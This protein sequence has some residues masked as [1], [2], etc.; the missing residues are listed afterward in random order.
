MRRLGLLSR[1]IFAFACAFAFVDGGCATAP[2]KDDLVVPVEV[3]PP[4]P[5]VAHAAPVGA[6]APSP[7]VAYQYEPL[8]PVRGGDHALPPYLGSDPCKMAL[9]GESPVAKACSERGLRGALQL[10]QTFVKRA[11][12]EGFTFVCTDCHAEED[13]YSRLTPIADTEFRKLLFLARPE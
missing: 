8:T 5:D 13:D 6:P 10:M 11:K 7:P 2:P 12:T 9:T 4:P 3:D 1:F